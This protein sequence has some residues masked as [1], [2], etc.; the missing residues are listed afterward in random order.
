MRIQRPFIAVTSE[1]GLLPADF[2]QE[3]L[4]PGSGIEG[5]SYAISHQWE[6]VPIHLLGSNIDL[7][8]RTER[9]AGRAL[10]RLVRTGEAV[11]SGERRWR[12]YTVSGKS[13]AHGA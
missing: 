4:K 10:D 12:R 13:I 11:A 3:L 7:D 6:T 5:K 1:G 2:L 8:K 9:V